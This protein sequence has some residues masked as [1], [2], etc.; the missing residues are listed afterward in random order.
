M[1]SFGKPYENRELECLEKSI[2]KKKERIPLGKR[3][4]IECSL[5]PCE[6]NLFNINLVLKKYPDAILY[7]SWHFTGHGLRYIPIN[8]SIKSREFA[9]LSKEFN[10]ILLLFRFNVVGTSEKFLDKLRPSNW[11][12]K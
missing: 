9:R 12:L 3:K 7:C 5:Y 11:F 10:C 1:D 2:K 6:Y 8:G 4:A